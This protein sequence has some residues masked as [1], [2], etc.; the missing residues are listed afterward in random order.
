MR[1]DWE[2]M[3]ICYGLNLFLIFLYTIIQVALIA[4]VSHISRGSIPACGVVENF[5]VSIS[6][7]R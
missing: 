3:C 6:S 4:F 7:R 1:G 2:W 5:L